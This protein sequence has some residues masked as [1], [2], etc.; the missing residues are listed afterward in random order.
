MISP[1]GSVQNLPEHSTHFIGNKDTQ[2]SKIFYGREC[3]F[4]AVR[5]I[6]AHPFGMSD[7]EAKERKTLPSYDNLGR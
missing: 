2:K 1:F 5:M 7:K 4:M 6:D 3:Q